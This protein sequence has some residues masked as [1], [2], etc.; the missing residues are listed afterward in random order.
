MG[1]D[2]ASLLND[3]EFE[4]ALRHETFYKQDFDEPFQMFG[5]A[6]MFGYRARTRLSPQSQTFVIVRFPEELAKAL[7]FEFTGKNG[8][9]QARRGDGP[10]G[11]SVQ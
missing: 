7:R 9:R 5:R 10:G 3:P 6:V 4:W 1:P 2:L 11:L 8:T